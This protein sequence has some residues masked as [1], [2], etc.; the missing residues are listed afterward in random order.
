[1]YEYLHRAAAEN[2]SEH[3]RRY[4][5]VERGVGKRGGERKEERYGERGRE[6]EKKK[7]EEERETE[8]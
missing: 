7:E 1:M 8:M 4:D 6:M 2:R 3:G 5:E